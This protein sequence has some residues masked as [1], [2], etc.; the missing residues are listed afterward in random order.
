M[1]QSLQS[2]QFFQKTVGS[3]IGGLIGDAIGTPTEGM[4]YPKI[5]EKFGWVT[6]FDCDGT[7]DT[8]MKYLLA[9]TLIRT[10]GYA[11]YDD[12]GQVW[13]DQWDEIF[14]DKIGKF[15]QSVIHTA[16]KLRRH[17]IPR[18]AALGNMPSSSSAMCISPVGIVNA[19][20][21]RQAAEQ[22]YNLASLIHVHD[23]SFCQ[24]GAAA[25]AA[26]TA[27][28]FLPE[29]TGDSILDAAVNAIVP[30]SGQEMLDLIKEVMAVANDTEDY[31]TFRQTMYEREADFFRP[32]ACDSRETVPITLALFRLA[33]GDTEKMV[34]YGANFGRDADTIATMGGA[35]AGAYQG[36]TGIRA[37][38]VEKARQLTSVDQDDLAERLILT[39]QAKFD[40]QE[41]ARK[42]FAAIQ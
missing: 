28:A 16:V 35:I 5:E 7:D 15:F 12:W 23:V 8:V 33:E 36:I 25:M 4:P 11:T 39:A 10:E 40:S 3:L 22:A 42:G 21:P 17:S 18:M 41:L 31:K 29:A 38:W 26:A 27:A 34:T 32:I 13:L 14:G 20:N 24:D 6:D 30:V 2:T 37:D 1:T 19:G 9:E